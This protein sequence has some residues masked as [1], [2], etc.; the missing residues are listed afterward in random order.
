MEVRTVGF[1][2][3]TDRPGWQI[4]ARAMRVQRQNAASLVGTT[5][6]SSLMTRRFGPA[7]GRKNS[8]M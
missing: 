6:V 8:I 4:C 3:S 5:R 7:A 2:R 1:A